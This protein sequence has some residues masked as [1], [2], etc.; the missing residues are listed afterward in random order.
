MG[1]IV[2]D[3][4]NGE[5]RPSSG[6]IAA[7]AAP[8]RSR[9]TLAVLEGWDHEDAHQPLRYGDSISLVP[10]KFNAVLAFA[11]ADTGRAWVQLLH[12]DVCVPPN[13]SD[14]Q[15]VIMPAHNFQESK[16]A[17][18]SLK[19]L[20]LLEGR[21]IEKLPGL[22][23]LGADLKK[24]AHNHVRA[25]KMSSSS[26][27]AVENLMVAMLKAHEERETN[28]AE[29]QR[30]WGS[31]VRFG[32]NVMLIQSETKR[33]LTVTK[34]RAPDGKAKIVEVMSD[35]NLNSI[36]IV[37]PGVRDQAEGG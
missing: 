17:H 3:S 6:D 9:T 34:K 19:R 28:V 22:P 14:C 24:A 11:G 13:M 31:F 30:Q 5:V 36:F 20:E 2:P 15:W 7:A 4:V 10:E 25:Q 21:K 18:K 32:A 29:D 37:K 1:D 35:G 16:K 8:K 12:E 26:A 33:V 23:P 27:Q